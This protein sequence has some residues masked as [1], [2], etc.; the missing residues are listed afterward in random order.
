MQRKLVWIERQGFQGWG[1]SECAWLFNPSGPPTGNSLDEMMRG[2]E[3]RQVKGFA[4]HV[5]TEHPRAKNRKG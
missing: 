2:Y 5:C 1:C 4:A 3:Q